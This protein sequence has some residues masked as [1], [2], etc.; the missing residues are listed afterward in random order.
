MSKV[1][2]PF[3]YGRRKE[4]MV[5]QRLRTRGYA[6]SLSEASRGASDIKA[7]GPKSW[8]IQ[9]RASCGRSNSNLSPSERR[10]IK[11]QARL[12]NA[13][14]VLAKVCGRKVTFRSVRT[15]KRLHP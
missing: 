5:A 12:D 8:N 15:G 1:K 9:V 2:H 6:T 7:R 14:P 10:R 3:Q 13:V 4:K 11:I